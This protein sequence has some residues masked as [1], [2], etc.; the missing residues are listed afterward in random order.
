MTAQEC[1]KM[2]E[3]CHAKGQYSEAQEYL[4]KALQ[5]AKEEL[6][7]LTPR[8]AVVYLAEKANEFF[9][10]EYKTSDEFSD[11]IKTYSELLARAQMEMLNYRDTTDEVINNVLKPLNLYYDKLSAWIFNTIQSSM[12]KKFPNKFYYTR[13]AQKL[14]PDNTPDL[15]EFGNAVCKELSNKLMSGFV[16]E[17]Y[18]SL[19]KH[20]ERILQRDY[21]AE[22]HW[23]STDKDRLDGLWNELYGRSIC[24][25]FDCLISLGLNISLTDMEKIIYGNL[26]IIINVIGDGA[27][28]NII[29]N[30]VCESIK[31]LVKTK[32]KED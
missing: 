20:Y 17:L 8:K 21:S 27:D 5:L 31:V 3:A 28:I 11:I 30:F 12:I 29:N 18:H 1:Y 23:F 4:Q 10:Q 25:V 16:I 7:N 32:D 19:K 6:P 26:S 9:E 22:Y 14:F 13:E 24:V 15:D 2:G